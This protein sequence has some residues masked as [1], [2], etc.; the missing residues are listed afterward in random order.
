MTKDRTILGI[1]LVGGVVAVACAVFAVAYWM[2]PAR[3]AGERI[4]AL[5]A[6]VK[7]REGEVTDLRIT[8]RERQETAKKLED[9]V[10][11]L[12][13][14]PAETPVEQDLS[15]ITDLA[16]SH[17]LKLGEVSPH[18]TVEYPGVHELRYILVGEGPFKDWVEFLA[19]FQKCSF[20]ADVTYVR[21]AQPAK[22]DLI[23]SAP[24]RTELTVSFYAAMEPEDEP[25]ATPRK[26]ARS[27]SQI[28]R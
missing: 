21:C 16:R 1:D 18:S 27:R 22:A 11:A 6:E 2:G 24:A 9:Q 15:T 8:L 23:S 10:R 19:S 4:R 26:A 25:P 20:W 14:L 3:A 5:Q 28:E 13:A 7:S 12:G 17:G